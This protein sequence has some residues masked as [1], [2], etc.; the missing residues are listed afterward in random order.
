VRKNHGKDRVRGS[1]SYDHEK[2]YVVDWVSSLIYNIYPKEKESL[3]KVNLSYNIENF[4]DE[5]SM[6][7][8]LNEE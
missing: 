8:V 4:I 6:H 3:E 1:L 2:E 7:H 5:N